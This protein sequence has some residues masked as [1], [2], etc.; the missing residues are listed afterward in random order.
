MK[1]TNEM[2]KVASE[3]TE[4]YVTQG[5]GCEGACEHCPFAEECK[6]SEGWWGCEAWEEGMGEDL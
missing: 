4:L 6:V 2:R 5:E 1:W 3:L